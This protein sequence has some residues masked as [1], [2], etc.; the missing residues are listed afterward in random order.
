[1]VDHGANINSV[2]KWKSTPLMWLCTNKSVTLDLVKYMVENGADI[3]HTNMKEETSLIWLCKSKSITLEKKLEIVKYMKK[4]VI[5]IDKEI[6]RI[7]DIENKEEII[8]E[9]KRI[10]STTKSAA[11]KSNLA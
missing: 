11:K 9:L 10:E 7:E 3:N 8:E 2:N 1:M 4:Y 6:E 5:D